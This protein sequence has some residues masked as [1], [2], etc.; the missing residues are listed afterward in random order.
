M[1]CFQQHAP[2][3]VEALVQVEQQLRVPLLQLRALN[4][5]LN[6]LTS[7]LQVQGQA[8]A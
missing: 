8:Q 3:G 4:L 1:S 5:E 2:D 6:H 7:Q